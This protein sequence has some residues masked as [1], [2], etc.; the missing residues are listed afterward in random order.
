METRIK[1]FSTLLGLIRNDT[2]YA[3]VDLVFEGGVVLTA[4]AVVL[5][6]T[7]DYYKGALSERWTANAAEVLEVAKDDA[8]SPVAHISKKRQLSPKSKSRKI[9][10]NHPN[11]SAETAKI[12]LDYLYLGDEEIP[13]SLASSVICFANEIL[14][15]S[16]VQNGNGNTQQSIQHLLGLIRKD[17]AYADVDLVFEDGIVLNA[18]AV[19]LASTSDYFKEA[20]SEKWTANAFDSLEMIDDK[21]DS[22]LSRISNKRPR[23]NSKKITLY[24]P[25][26]DAETA[27]IVLDYMY[28][29]DVDIPA[30]LASSVIEFA[31]EIMV[32]SLVQ[33]CADILVKEENLSVKNALAFYLLCDRKQVIENEKSIGLNKMLLNLPLSLESGRDVL[34]QMS[35]GDVET[36]LLFES[37]EPLHRWRILIAWCKSSLDTEGD[38][39]LESK[40]PEEFQIE[41]ASKLIEPLLPV[42]EL[43]KI[44][45]GN[46]CLME[47]FQVLLSESM[48]RMLAFH[49]KG[50]TRSGGNR[51]KSDVPSQP[52]KNMVDVIK[53]HL[54]DLFD[55]DALDYVLVFHGEP[56]TR[57]ESSLQSDLHEARNGTQNTLT[58][59]KLKTGTIFGEYFNEAWRG[60]YQQHDDTGEQVWWINVFFVAA[61]HAAALATLA[62]VTPTW[63]TIALTVLTIIAGELGITMG[64]HRLWSHA[65]YTATPPL[66]IL[67]ACMGALGFQGSIRWW[68]LRH[69]LH[70]RYTDDNTHDPYSAKRGFWF[71]HM[72]WIFAKPRYE[73]MSMVDARDLDSDSVVVFQHKYFV[74][75]AL[76]LCF[77]APF[78]LG[79]MWDDGYAAFLY[80]G[81]VARIVIW[82]LTFCINSFAHWIGDQEFSTESTARGTFLLAVLTQGEGYH[83]FHHEFPK[84]YRNGIHPLDWDPTKWLI[85]LA[86]RIGLASNLYTYPE[87]EINKARVTTM[88]ALAREARKKLD[89][90]PS[91]DTL[92]ILPWNVESISQS[93]GHDVWI[94]LDGFVLDVRAFRSEHPGGQKVVDIYLRKNATKA[95]YGVLNNHSKSARSM[96]EM[97]RVA[98]IEG[99]DAS[100]LKKED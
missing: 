24:H 99:G 94:G 75:V 97:L 87:N 48:Q 1:A 70:H 77:V 88:E 72:G 62:L 19:V 22:K 64:Y 8:D 96:V 11:V 47:P 65:A 93:V 38:L 13:A 32:F 17:T 74:P 12:V 2:T 81:I 16:L 90:G 73:R 69:R 50:T 39:S 84:D 23:S 57:T 79:S 53:Q 10:L 67:L 30:S 46:A 6:S 18:H 59:V 15:F 63:Q 42:V 78:M 3:D 29:G 14:V 27:K 4:H 60:Q 55:N 80:A 31:N 41:V 61:M 49:L 56:G 54:S 35:E 82:H 5:A 91:V 7:S 58:L 86:A 40:L 34:S 20:L 51:W 25:D 37:F 89:W 85:Y 66:R 9:T 76:S 98:R 83:N 92:P 95:F 36:M 28:L 43:F 33:K 100:L 26:V 44:S 21:A 68:V 71:S 52:G 45:A